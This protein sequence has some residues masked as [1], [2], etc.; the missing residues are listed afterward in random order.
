MV[1]HEFEKLRAI[2]HQGCDNRTSQMLDLFLV[3]KHNTRLLPN[4]TR[5]PLSWSFCT[6][7]VS[8]VWFNPDKKNLTQGYCIRPG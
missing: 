5:I 1:V 3:D 2:R 7:S 8:T 6:Q 4:S